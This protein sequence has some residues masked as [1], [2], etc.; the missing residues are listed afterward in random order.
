M[1]YSNKTSFVEKK[2][3]VYDADFLPFTKKILNKNSLKKNADRS[4][5]LSAILVNNWTI[6]IDTKIDQVIKNKISQNENF[7][8]VNGKIIFLSPQNNRYF[9]GWKNKISFGYSKIPRYKL[10]CYEGQDFVVG[11]ECK[12]CFKNNKVFYNSILNGK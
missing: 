7:N 6:G 8:V 2:I 10:K 3:T 9:S 1:P 12:N 11:D 5:T 4:I